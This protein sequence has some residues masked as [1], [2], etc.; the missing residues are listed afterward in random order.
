MVSLAR[1]GKA[2]QGYMMSNWMSLMN[3]PAHFSHS[4]HVLQGNSPAERAL[5]LWSAKTLG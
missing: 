3:G 5:C 4:G 1:G 2:G